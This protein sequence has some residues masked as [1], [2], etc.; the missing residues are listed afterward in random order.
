MR[1]A[2]RHLDGSSDRPDRYNKGKGS[3][4]TK[5]YGDRSRAVHHVSNHAADV[6]SDQKVGSRNP[7]ITCKLCYKG[8]DLDDCQAYLKKSLAERKEFLREKG[9]C[10]ACYDPGHRSNG[11][12]KRRTC[13]KCSRRHP[14]GLHDDNFRINQ[15]VSKQ[16][17]TPPP[18]QNDHVVNAHTE[19]DEIACNATNIGNSVPVRLRSAEGEVLTYAM[20]D[21]CSTGSFVLEDIVSGLGVKGADT[22]L[23]VK[24]VNGTK[25]YDAKVLNGLVVSDLKGD[26]TIQLPKIFTKRDLC[27]CENV[28]APDLAHY[29]KYLKD[30]EADLP[31]QLPNAKI[32]LLIGSNCPKALEPKDVLASKDGGPFA[33]KTFAGW[34]IVGPLYMCNEE[35]PTVDCHRVAAVE[36]CSG[37]HLDH[38][39]MVE[40]KVREIVTPQAVNK[41]FELDFSERTDDKELGYSQ[42]DKQFL[43]IVTQGIHHTEDG[44][45]EIPLPLCRDD[46]RFPENREQVFQRAHWLR[47]K[48]INNETFYKDYVNFMNSIIAKGF[49]RKIPSNRLFAKTGQVWYIPHHG[50]YHA[51]KPNKIRV[52]FDCGARFGGTSLNDQLLQVPDLTNR[53]VGVLTR[54]RQGPIAFMGDINAMFHQVRVPEGQQDLLRFLW[55]PDGDLTQNLEE[56]QMNV[57]LFGAVSSP[58]CSNFALRRAAD[59]AEKVIGSETANVLRKNL[60]V[61]DCLRTEETEEAAIQRICGVRH[62]CALGGFNLAKFVSNSRLVLESVPDEARAQDVRTLELGSGQLPVERALGVQWAIESDT[63]GFRIVLKDQPLTR[64]GILSTIS[65]VYDPLGIAAPFLLVG[66]S[67]LQDLCRAK[68]SW[69]EEIGE[70]YRVRWENWKSQLPA[71]E[72]FSMERCLK[73]ANFGTVVSRQLHNFSDASS[74]G[75]GQVTYIRIENEKGHIH[76]AFLMGKARVAPVKTMTI[77]RLELTAATVSAG[78]GEMIA[79][80][81]DEPAESKT[82]WTDSTTVLKYIRNDKKH[83]HVFVANRVQTI[84]DVTNPDQWSYVGTDINPADVSS[85]GMKG[86]ELSKQHLW[87]TGPNFLWLPECK[88]PQPPG[89]MDDVSHNDPEVKKVLVHNMDVEEKVDLLKRLA[90]FSEWHRMKKSIAWI[91]RLKP[92]TDRGALLPKGGAD[93]ALR[94]ENTNRKPLR[95]EELDRAEKTIL[96]LVQSGAFPNERKAL[97]EVRRVDCESDRQF[98]KAMKSEIKKSSTLYRLDPFL[99]KDGLIRVGGRLSKSQEFSE[100]FKHPVILPKKSIIVDL[101]VRDAHKRV[102]HAGRGITLS[103]LRSHYW[104]LNANSVVRHFISKCV[105][106]RRLCGTIGEQKM[107]DLP[108]ERI[109]SSSPFTY[110]GVDYFGPFYIKQGRK[111]VKRYGVLFTCLASRAVHI[112]T[113]DSLETNSFINALRRFIARRGPV[114]EIRSDQ[115]TNIVGVERELKKALDE[116]D[117]NTIQRSLCRDFN[118]DWIIQWK[119]NPPAASHMGGMWERQIRSVRSILSALMREHGHTLD[120][121]SFRTLLTEVECI[122]NSRPLTVPSSDPKDLDPLTPNHILTMKSRVV[123]PQTGNFQRA[124]LYLR[125]R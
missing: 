54:F 92:S 39:F 32:G 21:A 78:V 51:K 95:V 96:K 117:H 26:N 5:T 31:L 76:C 60:Y 41:M 107:A 45:Y 99:E 102:A 47:K 73:P 70:E 15:V 108:K 123:M 11:C 118:A 63:F 50:V 30:I 42:E 22:Q 53:L 67:I 93:R 66:K 55:W 94:T 86:H 74:T 25:L 69:D 27:T 121:E 44:H 14:T 57:H 40:N 90:R 2:L 104:I 97:Q 62:A 13:K 110:S 124:D 1:E 19:M 64:R 38:H 100:G 111:N 33:I 109:T 37:R 7:A 9:L 46:V 82:Y 29:W 119:Q 34:A 20:L 89:D 12:A 3:G 87:I 80:E 23:M 91:L 122:I 98:A 36:V 75:Y 85:R 65:S 16:Q 52:V 105:V 79:K 116:L 4:R 61:D 125:K 24:T 112:E 71:L 77:P 72:R 83:F 28:P 58:S 81:L 103:E 88:W 84:R 35:H 56:Y 6:T 17:I 115:G 43:K 18:P 68:L 59:D 106:C 48:L 113:A 101:I 114:R 10:F 49:A 120:D 8:H